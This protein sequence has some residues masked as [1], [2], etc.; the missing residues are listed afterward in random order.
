MRVALS[1]IATWTNNRTEKVVYEE[2]DLK[3]NSLHIINILS[4]TQG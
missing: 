3:P 2:S 4:A 1:L